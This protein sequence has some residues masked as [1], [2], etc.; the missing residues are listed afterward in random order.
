MIPIQYYSTVYYF[1]L[2]SVILMMIVSF[3]R[4]KEPKSY[5][6]LINSILSLIILFITISFVGL[7]DPWASSMYLGD[8]GAYTRTFE[9]IEAEDLLDTKDFGFTLFMY[10]SS[11][12]MNVRWFYFISAMLYVLLPYFAFKK[13]FNNRAWVALLVYVAAMSFWPFG[14]NGLRNGL[15]AAFF[16][17]GISLF[18]SPIKMIFWFVLSVG[19]HKSMLLPVVAFL[20]TFFIKNSR[21]LI[22]IWLTA[23]PIAFFFGNNLESFITGF[24]ESIEFDDKR[25]TNIFADEADGQILARSFRLDFILYSSVAVF[26]GYYYVIE[27]KFSDVLYIR[28]FNTYLIANTVWILMIYASYT[29]RTAYLSWFLM[30]IVLIY[31]LLKS[32]LVKN[33]NHWYFWIIFGSLLFTLIMFFFR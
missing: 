7:R 17:Y 24:F 19:F 33:Q 18:K 23:I 26:L 5:S 22:M 4:N 11:K 31:P 21:M 29:N 10:L 30:P 8:T 12:I 14:V 1:I 9:N 32:H 16:I 20:M 13:W 28:I 15:G 2:S 6:A 3:W 25:A 27:K